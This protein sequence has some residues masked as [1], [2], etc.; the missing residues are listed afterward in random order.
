[1]V[2]HKITLTMTNSQLEFDFNQISVFGLTFQLKP[3]EAAK[4]MDFLYYTIFTTQWNNQTRTYSSVR[5][6]RDQVWEVKAISKI[7][8]KEEK[9]S[10]IG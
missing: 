3:L 10:L 6:G 9:L 2:F 8:M 5:L 1:M 7:P 4:V